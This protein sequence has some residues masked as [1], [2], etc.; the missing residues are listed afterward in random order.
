MPVT[1]DLHYMPLPICFAVSPIGTFAR[2]RHSDP[3]CGTGLKELGS[4]SLV[5]TDKG[6]F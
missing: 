3:F 6:K 4:V 2:R 1:G 5:S